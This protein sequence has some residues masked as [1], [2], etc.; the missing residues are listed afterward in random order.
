LSVFNVSLASR[1]VA[2]AFGNSLASDVSGSISISQKF[3]SCLLL[4]VAALVETK[5]F[6]LLTL[7]IRHQR[8]MLTDELFRFALNFLS[9]KKPVGFQLKSTFDIQTL[10]QYWR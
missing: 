9:L 2:S 1:S 6:C 8:L 10:A 3:V 5:C 7:N 4:C